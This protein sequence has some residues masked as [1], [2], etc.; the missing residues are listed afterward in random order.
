MN[1]VLP[2]ALGLSPFVSL[3]CVMG[4]GLLQGRDVE[5]QE[6]GAEATSSFL[7]PLICSKQWLGGLRVAKAHPSAFAC[8]P[9]SG[10]SR[11][12]CRR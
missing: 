8:C 7:S 1:Q 6:E 5:E 3:L 2:M 12:S 10:N 9:S 11:C 4:N